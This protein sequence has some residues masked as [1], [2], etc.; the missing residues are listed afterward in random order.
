M[1][2]RFGRAG[3]GRFMILE[4][5]TA[6][7]RKLMFGAIL[8]GKDTWRDELLGS[9]EGLEVLKT[10]EEAEEE[11]MDPSLSDPVA[12][13]DRELSIINRRARAFVRLIDYLARHRQK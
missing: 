6:Q 9:P 13:L 10:M 5:K 8:L 7:I 1:G 3:D 11:F 12:R 2:E 4:N